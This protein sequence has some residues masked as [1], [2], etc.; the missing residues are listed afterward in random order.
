[1]HPRII[2]YDDFLRA[3]RTKY[4]PAAYQNAKGQEFTNLTQGV[5]IV[6]EYEVK[7]DQLSRYAMHLVASEQDKCNKFKGGLQME[8]KKGISARDMHTLMD[9]RE[10]ALRAER[11]IGEEF[12]MGR[13]E[14]SIG[15]TK[16]KH[17]YILWSTPGEKFRIQGWSF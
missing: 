16:G 12:S 13:Q 7:F 3:F 1:M 5:M 17:P 2:T 4:M 8:I 9:L 6:V 11:L 14:Q 10:V 15:Q